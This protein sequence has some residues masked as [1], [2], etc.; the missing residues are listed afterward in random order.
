MFMR[1]CSVVGLVVLGAISQSARADF[2]NAFAFGQPPEMVLAGTAA[3]PQYYATVTDGGDNYVNDADV[4][5]I[6]EVPASPWGTER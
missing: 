1:T 4:P 5:A 2:S 3:F 6:D